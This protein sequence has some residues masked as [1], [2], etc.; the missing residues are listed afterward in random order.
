MNSFDITYS[1]MRATNLYKHRWISIC[2]R[3]T[4][5]I[6][7]LSNSVQEKRGTEFRTLLNKREPVYKLRHAN[8][9]K[10]K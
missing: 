5:N 8:F 7:S 9:S 6:I 2:W 1:L 10:V 4:K 3:N